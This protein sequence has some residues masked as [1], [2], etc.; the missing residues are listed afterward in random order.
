MKKMIYKITLSF[1]ITAGLF[2]GVVKGQEARNKWVNKMKGRFE[3]TPEKNHPKPG[4][5]V[6]DDIEM[7][8][9]HNF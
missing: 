3:N 5:V 4:E 6:L 8:A 9:F 1:I 7:A 2:V